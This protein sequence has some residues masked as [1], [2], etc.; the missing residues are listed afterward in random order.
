MKTL[1]L[2]SDADRILALFEQ[3]HPDC[4]VVGAL[5]ATNDLDDL[6]RKLEPD[7]ILLGID[8]PEAL[9]FTERTALSQG[10]VMVVL[11]SEW[12]TYALEA[13][14]LGALDFLLKPLSDKDF[15]R[16]IARSKTRLKEREKPNG[17]TD[18]P[19]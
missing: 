7:L 5:D 17:E 19:G 15:D 14:R 6:I 18:E 16:S 12:S 2:D 1:I 10:S 8:Q 13:I 4:Q 11:L 9:A 3:F